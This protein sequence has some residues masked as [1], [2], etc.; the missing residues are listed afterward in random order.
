MTHVAA[1]FASLQAAALELL[2]T[3]LQRCLATRSRSR[4]QAP[5]SHRHV[6]HLRCHPNTLGALAGSASQLALCLQAAVDQTY[7]CD[8]TRF[9][10]EAAPPADLETQHRQS[11]QQYNKVACTTS[12]AHIGSVP[13]I[14]ST[15]RAKHEP[16]VHTTLAAGDAGVMRRQHLRSGS[17]FGRRSPR[18]TARHRHGRRTSSTRPYSPHCS[19]PHFHSRC[20][21]HGPKFYWFQASAPR[22]GGPDLSRVSKLVLTLA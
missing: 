1:R 18:R 10:P 6:P 7:S 17:G 21:L 11:V 13:R 15:A 5:G 12:T 9:H 16:L 19:R 3:S 14:C 20:Y 4:T 8:N 2:Y 22:A